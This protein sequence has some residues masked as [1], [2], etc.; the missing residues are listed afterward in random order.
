[1]NFH[2]SRPSYSYSKND[3]NRILSFAITYELIESGKLTNLSNR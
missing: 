2:P 3:A 1:M